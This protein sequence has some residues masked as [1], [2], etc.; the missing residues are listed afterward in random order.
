M[1]IDGHCGALCTCRNC[2]NVVL[3]SIKA[4][5]QALLDE[6]DRREGTIA[7]LERKVAKLTTTADVKR[8]RE[9]RVRPRCLLANVCI[10]LPPAGPL[11]CHRLWASRVQSSISLCVFPWVRHVR[12]TIRSSTGQVEPLLTGFVFGASDGTTSG[13]SVGGGIYENLPHL[14]LSLPRPR[15]KSEAGNY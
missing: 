13:H 3:R 15:E 8:E 11:H 12:H 2:S 14:S 5:K 1:E 6:L 10:S 7:E 4:E 9:E